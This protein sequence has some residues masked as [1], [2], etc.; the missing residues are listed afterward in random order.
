MFRP[1]SVRYLLICN[2]FITTSFPS[3]LSS[4]SNPK[5]PLFIEIFNSFIPPPHRS[6]LLSDPIHLRSESIWLISLHPSTPCIQTTLDYADPPLQQVPH[7]S[8]N[9]ETDPINVRCIYHHGN[10]IRTQ[11]LEHFPPS[12][13]FL[14]QSGPLQNS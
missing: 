1:F 6:I 7:V 11:K 3:H 12:V 2:P 8:T 5:L 4:S 13:Y 10:A 14:S 9:S